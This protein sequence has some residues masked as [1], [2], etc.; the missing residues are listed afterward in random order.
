M[1]GTYSLTGEAKTIG[2]FVR[3][4][5][6]MHRALSALAQTEHRSVN[7]QVLYLLEMA[8]KFQPR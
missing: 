3:M 5:P 6:R 7:S 4:T 2:V 8:L 1:A